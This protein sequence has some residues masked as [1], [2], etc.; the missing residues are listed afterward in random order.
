MLALALCPSIPAG[1]CS[2]DSCMGRGKEL[3]PG[4]A[5]KITHK[6]KALD[7]VAVD[8][9]TNGSNDKLFSGITG[10]DG[11]VYVSNLPA[12]DYWLK[13][14]F[15][16]ISAANQCFHVESHPSRHAKKRLTF[17]WGDYAPTTRRV[18]GRIIDSQAGTGGTMLWN[19]TH[20]VDTPISSAS[21]T[22]KN[23]LTGVA[24]TAIS[25]EK[26]DFTF[27]DVP[28]GTYV[29]HFNGGALKSGS[30][31]DSTDLLI[32]VNEKAVWDALLLTNRAAGGGSCGG[33]SLE[34][35]HAAI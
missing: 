9:V 5:V 34:V 8:V 2:I 29:L 28:D 20:R 10:R 3:R 22:L 7:G 23:A 11:V 15:F 32:K 33:M 17:M 35:L 4:F 1:A 25:D 18:V 21:A 27:P 24:Y 6:G 19:M 16:R 30:A 14:N 31:Y 13:V 12:G 26:G